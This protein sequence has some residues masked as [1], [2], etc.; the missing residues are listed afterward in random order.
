MKKLITICLLAT[1][2]AFEA[3]AQD[4]Y[5]SQFVQVLL[6]TLFPNSTP[7]PTDCQNIFR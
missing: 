5:H 1:M 6:V 2:G 4:T 7:T 3:Q